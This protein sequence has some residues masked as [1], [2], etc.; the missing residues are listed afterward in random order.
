MAV[1]L[2]AQARSETLTMARPGGT[3]QLFWEPVTTT[4]RPQPS[5][6]KGTAPRPLMPSTMMSAFGCRAVDGG[7]DVRERV[8]DAGRGLVVG[9]Q[10][11]LGG[12]ARRG[13]CPQVVGHDRSGSAASTPLDG[14]L[15]DVGAVAR[16][17]GGEPVP[18]DADADRQHLVAGGQEVDHDGL[19]ATGARRG[20]E[21]D[22]VRGPEGLLE[23]ARHAS[24]QRLELG[25]AVVDHLPRTGLADRR[26]QR[27]GS[28]DAQVGRVGHVGTPIRGYRDSVGRA[29]TAFVTAPADGTR[30]GPSG[31]VTVTCPRCRPHTLGRC[32]LVA[33][34][35]ADPGAID[36]AGVVVGRG[37]RAAGGA[38]AAR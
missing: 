31:T 26:G 18:E 2:A 8:G 9:H 28:G 11:G 1:S 29:R 22:V 14:V 4:S 21:Q 12:R 10:D 20:Q 33:H 34:L 37:A 35:P 36:A 19:Q 23:A 13:Q 32:P 27:G 16:G 17:D 6:S 15:V 24:Q 7:G 30:D 38:D 5:V 3:I 25:T